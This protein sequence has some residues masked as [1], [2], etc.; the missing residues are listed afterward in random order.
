MWQIWSDIHALMTQGAYDE[1]LAE[2]AI[3]R[4]ECRGTFS[5]LFVL[6]A[7]CVARH[8]QPE[9]Y[10]RAAEILQEATGFDDRNYWVY[11]NLAH[12]LGKLG[13]HA[14]RCLPSGVPMRSTAGQRVEKRDTSSPTTIFHQTSRVGRNGSPT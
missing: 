12:F 4:D 10:A 2:I 7:A 13:V 9:N 8:G 11:Y 1:A 5:P 3:H 6:E 14:R